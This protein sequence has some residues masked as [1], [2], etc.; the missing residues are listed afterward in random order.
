MS[1]IISAREASIG[2]WVRALSIA[3]VAL[4]AVGCAAVRPGLY[5]QALIDEHEICENGPCVEALVGGAR[6]IQLTWTENYRKSARASDLYSG[7]LIGAGLAVAAATAFSGSKDTITALALAAGGIAASR[8]FWAR[9]GLDR[10]YVS[11]HEAL[12]CFISRAAVFQTPYKA[13]RADVEAAALYLHARIAEQEEALGNVTD[14]QDRV[15]LVAALEAARTVR[16]AAFADMRAFD[17]AYPSLLDVLRGIQYAVIRRVRSNREVDYASIAGGR[18]ASPVSTAERPPLSE[19][20]AVGQ[21][22]LIQRLP[23]TSRSAPLLASATLDVARRL[24]GWSARLREAA[25]CIRS[26][27]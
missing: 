8:D 24:P 18:Y 14:D 4:S 13:T 16:T 20:A 9:P 10:I 19:Q 21:A 6:R 11:G 5:D 15:V 7:A 12:T 26:V 23:G 17:N 27:E 25:A 2:S 1:D 3:V 22:E